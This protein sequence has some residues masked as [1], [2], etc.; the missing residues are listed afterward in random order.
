MKILWSAFGVIT[1]SMSISSFLAQHSELDLQGVFREFINFYREISSFAFGWAPSLVGVSVPQWLCDAW[2]LSF[3]LTAATFRMIHYDYASRGILDY[4]HR[5]PITVYLFHSLTFLGIINA[6][7]YCV[8]MVKR[9]PILRTDPRIG[10]RVPAP[11]YKFAGFY[12]LKSDAYWFATL[13]SI[14]GMVVLFFIAS[15]YGPSAYG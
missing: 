8:P 11:C 9:S 13:G 7:F 6:L 5:P 4:H 1:G 10:Q 2:T 14:A 15:A 3:V 12:F